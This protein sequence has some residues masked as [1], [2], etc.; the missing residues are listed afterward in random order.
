MR[1]R[2]RNAAKVVI[3]LHPPPNTKRANARSLPVL[4]SVY[5]AVSENG[6]RDGEPL[7]IPRCCV[8]VGPIIGWQN[9]K[10]KTFLAVV[11]H[12]PCCLIQSITHGCSGRCNMPMGW[13]PNIWPQDI[14]NGIGDT[15][16]ASRDNAA[17]TTLQCPTIRR[18]LAR[19][20]RPGVE[21][22]TRMTA[23]SY[24]AS[25]LHGGRS[26]TRRLK[27]G[28]QGAAGPC[29]YANFVALHGRCVD[30]SRGVARCRCWAASGW[31]TALLANAGGLFRQR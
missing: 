31:L 20:H 23:C 26:D 28:S 18:R 21:S 25:S 2:S 6:W 12:S 9:S 11:I 10:I 5:G 1:N 29:H 16:T 15:L 27:R 22:E 30:E 24:R 13:M 14:A 19:A 17:V 3:K 4:R 8:A 7:Q